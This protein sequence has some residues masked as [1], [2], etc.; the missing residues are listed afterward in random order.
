MKNIKEFS[1]YVNE[2]NFNSHCNNFINEDKDNMQ[3]LLE[4][5]KK[6]NIIIKDNRYINMG[7]TIR[8]QNFEYVTITFDDRFGISTSGMRIFD[9]DTINEYKKELNKVSNITQRLN[10]KLDEGY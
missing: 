8:E 6:D 4:I 2:I 3:Y 1:K 10:N 9:E 7:F 5:L